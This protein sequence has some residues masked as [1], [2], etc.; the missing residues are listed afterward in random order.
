MQLYIYLRQGMAA[1]TKGMGSQQIVLHNRYFDAHNDYLG[2]FHFIIEKNIAVPMEEAL[3]LHIMKQAR[4]WGMV[5]YEQD[6]LIYSYL[7]V[8]EMQI[9]VTNA[10]TWL[11][12]MERAAR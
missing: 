5:V 1:V 12:S 8:T 3:F 10:R 9:N 2:M 7:N 6:W 11:L 4:Q